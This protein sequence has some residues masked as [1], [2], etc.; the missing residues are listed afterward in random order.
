[1]ARIAIIGAGAVGVAIAAALEQA[2]RHEIVLCARG[3][4]AGLAVETPAGRRDVQARI[5]TRA[6]DAGRADWVLVATKAYDCP[7]A[8]RWFTGLRGADTPVAVLQN[9][10]EH[11]ERFAPYAPTPMIV[12]VVVN[13]QAERAGPAL[14]RLRGEVDLAVNS[15]RGGKGFVR[16][17]EGAGLRARETSGF[18]NELWRKLCLN[19]PGAIPALLLQPARVFRDAAV[20]D[21]ARQLVRECA[22]VA[23]AEGADPGDT[24]EHEVAAALCASAPDAVNSLHADRLAGR[25][26]EFDARNGAVVRIGAKHGIATPAN[27]LVTVLLRAVSA[28]SEENGA[29]VGA[30]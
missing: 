17:F 27:A 1:M 3:A 9:G 21:S 5:V 12:P 18:R 22:C 19:V 24:V 14:V 10:V 4:L 20:L 23:R 13:C 16:L 29:P 11:V 2:G 26:L 28:P 30:P 8:A 25:P 15:T 6:Q 7:G